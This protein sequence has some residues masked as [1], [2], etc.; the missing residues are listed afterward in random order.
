[1]NDTQRKELEDKK[2]RVQLEIDKAYSEY[3][4]YKGK[5]KELEIELS[6]VVRIKDDYLNEAKRLEDE[7]YTIDCYLS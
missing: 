2:T 3:Y 6:N 7:L 5:E 1:M 4:H